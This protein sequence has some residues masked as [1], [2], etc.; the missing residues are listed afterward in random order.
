LQN[1]W[2]AFS[3]AEVR[4]GTGTILFLSKLMIQNWIEF[5]FCVPDCPQN[6]QPKRK[7]RIATVRGLLCCSR[8]LRVYASKQLAQQQNNKEVSTVYNETGG[9]RPDTASDPNSAQ[10]LQTARQDVAH[11]Y[12]NTNGNGF[13]SSDQ[14]SGREKAAIKNGD[15]TAVASMAS[16]QQAV[17]AAHQDRTDPTKGATHIYLFDLSP[18]STQRVPAWVRNGNPTTVQG[19]FINAAG[20]GM[21]APVRWY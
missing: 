11:V 18:N 12:E 19:P 17:A 13:Q 3:R 5:G 8:S 15:P 1:N 10:N 20:G 2:T 14:L 6:I 16:S 7:V 21:Y 4:A 9:L